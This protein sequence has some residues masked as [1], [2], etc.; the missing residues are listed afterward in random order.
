MLFIY[1]SL[2]AIWARY[3]LSIMLDGDEIGIAIICQSLELE[4]VKSRS[5]RNKDTSGRVQSIPQVN[6]GSRVGNS[7]R[8]WNAAMPVGIENNLS[9]LFFRG[10]R[11]L[12]SWVFLWSLCYIIRLAK[13]LR[14]FCNCIVPLNPRCYFPKWKT[15]LQG[16]CSSI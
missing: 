2:T 13:I 16:H 4:E 9:I 8:W 12:W 10:W 1:L 7:S 15:S 5:W 6:I 11:N 3:Y 14:S